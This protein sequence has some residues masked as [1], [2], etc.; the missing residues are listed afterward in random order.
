MTEWRLDH[1]KELFPNASESF[2]RRNVNFIRRNVKAA[3]LAA[4]GLSS[5]AEQKPSEQLGCGRAVPR[6]A[7]Y[8]VRCRISITS[9]RRRLTDG[10]WNLQPEHF[11]DAL[12]ELGLIADD[13]EKEIEVQVFQDKVANAW[14]ERTVI[15]IEPLNQH[16]A[17]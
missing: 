9:Y 16:E 5:S 17:A 1:L 11:I 4:R 10:P 13:S 15:M 7:F 14:E 6:K 12:T 8:Q 2:I 3:D